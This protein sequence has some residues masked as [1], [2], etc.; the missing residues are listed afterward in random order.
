MVIKILNYSFSK[1][2]HTSHQFII[3][4]SIHFINKNLPH[5]MTDFSNYHI[6]TGF[7]TFSLDS[8]R[9]ISSWFETHWHIDIFHPTYISLDRI[10]IQVS[11][12]V[13]IERINSSRN[14]NQLS[15]LLGSLALPMYHYTLHFDLFVLPLVKF[16]HLHV[17]RS[18][19]HMSILD[20]SY[21]FL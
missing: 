3:L 13:E 9:W 14:S 1:F 7:Q 10:R 8:V 21:Y 15:G 16:D 5:K 17:N 4:S 20:Y 18:D 2:V 6:R 12:E 11:F 19:F